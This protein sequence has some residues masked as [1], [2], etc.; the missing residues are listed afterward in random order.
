M[1]YTL[2]P[3]DASAPFPDI[4]LALRDPD[5][6]LAVGGDLSPQRLVRAYRQ[7]IFPWYS[8]GQPPLWWSPDPRAVVFPERLHVSRSL[9][10][11]L[12]QGRFQVTLDQAF[13]ATVAGCA[14]PR[15]ADGGTWITP[16][17]ATAYCRLHQL[18]IAHSAE[19]WR[20]GELAGGIYGLALG[21][22]FFGESM[23]SRERDASKVAFVTLVEQL[24]EW[25]Y[26]LVDCQVSSPHLLS[27]GM[28]CIPR[29]KF[30]ALLARHCDQL[31]DGPWR[32]TGAG[33]AGYGQD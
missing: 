7:G 32:D 17:M 1:L 5:G 29:R 33:V 6:L 2:D 8:E 30:A 15:D 28:E 9:G 18:G 20:E 25:N 19:V 26:T 12:R 14:A 22:V 16:E 24:R 13:S 27:F 11:T 4:E 10:K 23:F 3:T 31:P 21:R